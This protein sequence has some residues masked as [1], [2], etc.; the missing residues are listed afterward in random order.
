MI[1]GDGL[2]MI[3]CILKMVAHAQNFKSMKGFV[4]TQGYEGFVKKR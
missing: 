2:W 1:I 4:I 3:A